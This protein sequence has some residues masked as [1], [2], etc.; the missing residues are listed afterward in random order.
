MAGSLTHPASPQTPLPPG[1]ASPSPSPTEEAPPHQSIPPPD[2][3]LPMASALPTVT[4][5]FPCCLLPLWEH[6]PCERS[7]IADTDGT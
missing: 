6:K 2:L 3:L 4:C 7:L 5:V 1:A